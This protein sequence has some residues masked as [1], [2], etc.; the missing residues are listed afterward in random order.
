MAFIGR[1]VTYGNF[2][3]QVLTPDSVTTSFA[4]TFGVGAAGSILVVYGGIIQQ[5]N[6][7]YTLGNGGQSIVFSEA[8]VT[9]TTLYVVYMGKQMYTPRTVGNEVITQSFT[10]DGTTTIFTLSDNPVTTAGVLVFVDGVQQRVGSGNNFQVVGSTIVFSTAPDAS[11]EIDAYILAK[12]RANV[13][14]V[15][16]G[17]ITRTMVNASLTRNVIGQYSIISANQTVS[18]GNYYF[19]D[20]SSSAL[21]LTLPSSALLGDT[22]RFIDLSGTFGTNNLTVARNSSVIQRSATD[23]TVSTTGAAFDLVYSNATNGWIVFP[24]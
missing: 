1:D 17:V 18:A 8:P 2:E 19:V 23:L 13:D 14:T 7:S 6:V 24:V 20:T 4:L 10:G 12:E 22:I 9:G 21:T 3:S 16:P 11:A 15:S 5:P